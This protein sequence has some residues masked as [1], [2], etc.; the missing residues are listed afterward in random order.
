MRNNKPAAVIISLD[1]CKRLTKAE[2]ENFALRLEAAERL[3]KGDG[4]RLI[5]EEVFGN[6]YR[7]VED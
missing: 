4:D 6:D 1:D 2:E 5:T 7:P 3:S